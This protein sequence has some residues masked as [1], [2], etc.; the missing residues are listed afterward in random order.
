MYNLKDYRLGV[1]IV[2]VNKEGKVFAGQRIDS[3]TE[4]WQMPQGGVEAGETMEQAALRELA[5]EVGTDKVAIIGETK[6]MLYYDLPEE[7][8]G[9]LWNGKYK[10]Q[11]QKW[12]LM[13][14]LGED[15]DINIATSLPEFIQWHWEDP[16]TLARLIV[17][18]KREIYLRVLGEFGLI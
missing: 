7:L 14:F 1:G 11:R 16:A 10:G 15:A 4:S 13:R 3:Q 17:P 8:L 5:E 9:K 6:E 2:L 12:L 18:F